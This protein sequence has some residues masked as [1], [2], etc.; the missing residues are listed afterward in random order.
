MALSSSQVG[1][2]TLN[3]VTLGS[4]PTRVTMPYKNPERQ[5]AYQRDHYRRKRDAYLERN[6]SDRLRVREEVNR[7]KEK[8]GCADCGIPY[9]YYVLD[10]DH[11]DGEEKV[12]KIHKLIRT[13][14]R[15]AV[16]EEIGKCDVVCANCHRIRTF[17]RLFPDAPEW[18][19]PD[20]RKTCR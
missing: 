20:R 1:R 9:P 4:N 15:S 19:F 11:R 6:R 14:S 8:L 5:K 7:I 18:E 3:P 17:R 10:F 16:M 12:A 2:W 13:A